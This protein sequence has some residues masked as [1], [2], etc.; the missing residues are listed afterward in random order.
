ME[1]RKLYRSNTNK[2]LAGV[3]GGLGEFLGIDPTLI[4]LAFVLMGLLGGH[5]FLVYLIMC[6]VVPSSPTIS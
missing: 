2:M 5:G 1:N 3:C 6:I 4:R